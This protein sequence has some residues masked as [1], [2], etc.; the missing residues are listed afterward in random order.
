MRLEDDL[1][2]RQVL[3]EGERSSAHRVPSIVLSVLLDGLLAQN[4][5]MLI[6]HHAQQEDRI[7]GIQ[8]E[9]DGVR[10]NNRNLLDHVDVL[11]DQHALGALELP[12]EAE[13]HVLGRHLPTALVELYA[14]T[15]LKRPLRAILRH[16]PAFCQIRLYFRRGHFT[17]FDR[18]A[19]QAPIDETRHRLYWPLRAAMGVET[20]GFLG[21]KMQNS[22][23]S[24]TDRRRCEQCQCYARHE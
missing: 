5:P 16:R 22:L 20:L 21:S 12:L 19:R 4:V 3:V 7:V 9:L 11:T 14:L 8:G 13:L 18:K 1:F 6:P 2:P 17:I 24:S 10:V 15:Q 23:L